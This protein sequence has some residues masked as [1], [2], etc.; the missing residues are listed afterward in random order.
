MPV[1][2]KGIARQKPGL[3]PAER[4]ENPRL[5]VWLVL[6]RVGHEGLASRVL[7]YQK[8]GRLETCPYVVSTP[9]LA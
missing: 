5:R 6:S 4:V 2:G 3:W 1:C 9:T 8:Q 7:D